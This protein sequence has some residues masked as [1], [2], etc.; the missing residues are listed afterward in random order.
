M[1]WVTIDDRA[2]AGRSDMNETGKTIRVCQKTACWWRV[3]E[4]IRNWVIKTSDF[5]PLNTHFHTQPFHICTSYM[6]DWVR[7]HQQGR[8]GDVFY[9]QLQCLKMPQPRSS[10]IH[11]AWDRRRGLTST[12]PDGVGLCQPLCY[13][14]MSFQVLAHIPRFIWPVYSCWKNPHHQL[15][16]TAWAESHSAEAKGFVIFRVNT[17]MRI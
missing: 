10:H 8:S 3:R 11:S 16:Y 13:W 9:Y 14:H 1:E 6:P 4:F 15:S 7:K 12:G 5:L 2:R 17:H